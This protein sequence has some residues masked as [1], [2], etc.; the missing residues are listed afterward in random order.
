M[1]N[2]RLLAITPMMFAALPLLAVQGTIATDATEYT[3]EIKWQPRAKSYEVSYKK[4]KTTVSAEIKLEELSRLDIPKPAA[5]DK[6]VE[7]V[8]RGQ[9]AAAISALD[10]LVKEYRMLNWDKPAGRYLV[11]AYL[12]ADQV[13]KA[14]E[15]CNAIIAEDKSAAYSGDLAMAYWQVLLRQ[16]KR[17]QLDSLMAKAITSGSRQAAA[18]AT[19]MRGDAIMSEGDSPDIIRRA[20]RDGYLRVALMY[21]DP[22]CQRERV[23]AAEKAAKCLDKIGFSSRAEKLRTMVKAL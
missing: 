23:E 1:V 3:G 7:Q 19:V 4:G 6:A 8:E 21:A 17:D 16:G 22:E 2:L 18:A 11:L 14:F 20:L 5:F 9:G 13:Q 10:K 12:S 15:T